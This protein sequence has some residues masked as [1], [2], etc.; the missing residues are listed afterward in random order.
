MFFKIH[1]TFIKN[2]KGEKM[3]KWADYLISKV[4]YSEN[5]R[6]IISVFV[7][8]DLGDNVGEGKVF[9]RPE[10]ISLIKKGFSVYTK[11]KG[12]SGW[13]LGEPVQIINVN[14]VE[15]I[16]TRPDSQSID[17]LENLPEF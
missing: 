16:K 9:S 1:K 7:H 11:Y 17:N 10:V 14:A 15:F 6:H 8:E 4:R 5:P 2:Y 13:K 3:K 12:D